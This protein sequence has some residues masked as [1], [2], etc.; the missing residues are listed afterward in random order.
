MVSGE[1]KVAINAPGPVEEVDVADG[2]SIRA[3]LFE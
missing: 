2:E 3:S 1:G